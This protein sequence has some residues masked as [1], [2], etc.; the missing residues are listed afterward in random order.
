MGN[1]KLITF[2]NDN[3]CIHCGEKLNLKFDEITIRNNQ[4]FHDECLPENL[5]DLEKEE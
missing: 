4:I 1:D 5:K 3:Y 2:E